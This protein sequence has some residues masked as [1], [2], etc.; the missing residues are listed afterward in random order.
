MEQP[1][2]M[3][4]IIRYIIETHVEYVVNDWLVHAGASPKEPQEGPRR[5]KV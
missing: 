3:K 5:E 1:T 4:D 2:S